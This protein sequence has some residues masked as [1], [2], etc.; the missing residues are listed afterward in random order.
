MLLPVG[1]AA[2]LRPQLAGFSHRSARLGGADHR[3]APCH[4]AVSCS[5]GQNQ[6][7][8]A[9]KDRQHL[10]RRIE[11]HLVRK[12][13]RPPH[14][15]GQRGEAVEHEG[16]CG[17]RHRSPRAVVR[18]GQGKGQAGI[19]SGVGKR[20]R[21]GDWERER[22]SRKRVIKHVGIPDGAG[23]LSPRL[24]PSKTK[25]PPSSLKTYG[26][27]NPTLRADF[28]NQP[29]F[30]IALPKHRARTSV[31]FPSVSTRPNHIHRRVKH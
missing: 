1:G 18:R 10:R 24:K 3:L 12:G 11:G 29:T 22:W 7:V 30:E 5:S 17:A 28:Q 13:D 31:S 15:L 19:C 23:S 2:R 21:Q 20:R 25:P 8:V 4:R 9:I 14:G 16:P 6:T 26:L 27:D